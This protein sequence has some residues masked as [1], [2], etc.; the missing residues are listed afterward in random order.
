[1]TTT[2]NR[3]RSI[4]EMIVRAPIS[5]FARA[6]FRDFR[7]FDMPSNFELKMH[8]DAAIKWLERAHE[9]SPDDGVSHS[10]SIK[11]GWRPSYVETTGYI[12]ETF[13]DLAA[14]RNLPD[15]SVRAE[16]MAR[17]LLAAQLSDG[18][19]PNREMNPGKGL[20]FDTG[21]DLFGLIRAYLE[22]N[23]SVFLDAALKAGEWLVKTS[24]SEQRWTRSTAWALLQLH[25]I[26]PRDT[27]EEVARAN[28]DWA[29]TQQS[30]D[31]WFDCCAFEIDVSPFTH[32]IAYAARGLL[33]SGRLLDDDRYLE[34][35]SRVARAT[36]KKVREDGF[37]P[38][39]IG[40]D[41]SIVD[42][43]CCLTGNCQFAIVWIKL[44]HATGEACYRDAAKSALRYVMS[45]QPIDVEDPNVRGG[46]A[47][48]FPIW[49]SYHRL[50][51]PNWAAK[52]F[53][54]AALMVEELF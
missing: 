17:W 4:I 38:G 31:G 49:G 44:F 54:D 9:M 51:Y 30:E 34:S 7:S 47:G 20:V 23:D 3:Y 40:A 27:F 43:Y 46:I 50:Q 6:V 16:R 1:M 11:G 15:Y 45:R 8:I 10:Y 36:V 35:A 12:I 13:Y 21:Q 29:I 19:F 28:L 24:D 26:E 32:T 18:S 52:F 25:S 5:P 14:R 2:A 39:Q 33:E 22:T 53:I 41:G 37:L 48:S 42:S